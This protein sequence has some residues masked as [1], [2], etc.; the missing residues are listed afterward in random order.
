MS[1]RFLKNMDD[2][3]KSQYIVEYDS[4]CDLY[5]YIHNIIGYDKRNT[6]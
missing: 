3:T 5:L 4:A 1:K 2:A 6:G